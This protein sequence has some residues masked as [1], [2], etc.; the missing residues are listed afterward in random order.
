MMVVGV[1]SALNTN[2]KKPRKLCKN[3]SKNSKPTEK[4][5]TLTK[6]PKQAL[7]YPVSVE[8]DIFRFRNGIY[9]DI[10]KTPQL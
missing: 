8:S 1:P 3:K 5:T 2:L 6:K 9:M 10:I 7:R 4:S